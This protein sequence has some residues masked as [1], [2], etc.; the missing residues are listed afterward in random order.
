MKPLWV[1]CASSGH[2]DTNRTPPRLHIPLG[3]PTGRRVVATG[4]AKPANAGR[5]GTRSSTNLPL[6]SSIC[7]PAPT[8]RRHR[9][10]SCPRAAPQKNPTPAARLL[11]PSSAAPLDRRSLVLLGPGAPSRVNANVGTYFVLGDHTYVYTA[12]STNSAG[13]LSCFSI[14]PFATERLRANNGWPPFATLPADAPIPKPGEVI[15][16]D[17]CGWPLASLR[18]ETTKTTA[19]AALISNRGSLVLP[20][21][22]GRG[23]L[24]V[25]ARPT[26]GLLAN[27]VLFATALALADHCAIA[28]HQW[29]R[30]RRGHCGSCN[31]NRH[32]L[33]SDAPCPECGT[34]PIA[35]G[36]PHR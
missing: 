12:N 32:G 11:P 10:L 21:I 4:E 13:S 8:G 25:P 3:V 31:Y 20:R 15:E 7:L 16:H 30:R 22:G 28:L 1:P 34:S 35:Q 9:T 23:T 27:T 33:T 24:A 29:T 26:L 18:S 14:D 17:W 6:P 19:S 36:T 2:A 5:S